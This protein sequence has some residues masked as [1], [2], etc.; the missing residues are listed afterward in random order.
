VNGVPRG[1]YLARNGVVELELNY[2]KGWHGERLS[3]LAELPGLRSFEIFDFGIRDIRGI[4]HLHKLKRLG[5]TTYCTTAIDF[6][7]FP[8]LESCGLEWRPKATSLFECVTL[9]ELFVNRYKGKDLTAFAKLVNLETLAILNSPI[10]SLRGLG[11][12][13]K[14]RSLRLANLQRLSALSGIEPLAGLE[15]LDINTW[16]LVP[17]IPLPGSEIAAPQAAG[18]ADTTVLARPQRQLTGANLPRPFVAGRTDHDAGCVKTAQS[19]PGA[20]LCTADTTSK[21]RILKSLA[22]RPASGVWPM[23]HSPLLHWCIRS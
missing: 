6:S 9:K 21:Y 5:V 23:Q 1:E 16:A 22:L 4:H 13:T 15:E 20:D 14:L 8:E 7:A 17:I 12:V 3:F 19:R 2:A 11:A 18:A 10:E